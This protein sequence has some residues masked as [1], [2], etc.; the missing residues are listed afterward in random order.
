AG[1]PSGLGDTAA[2][3]VRVLLVA[4]AVD[5]DGLPVDRHTVA[6]VGTDLLDVAAD[7]FP[8]LRIGQPV[9]RGLQP[10]LGGPA[11]QQRGQI[12][13]AGQVRVG[14]ERD[15]HAV[16]DRVVH[17]RQ[18]LTRAAGVDREV[19]RGVCQ[20]KRAAGPPGDLDHLGVRLQR[21]GAVAAVVRTVVAAT[22]CDDLAQRDQLVGV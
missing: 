11:G 21:T 14:V 10:A 9:E 12:G 8:G 22:G 5:L 6:A 2:E 1:D 3:Q 17:Q 13:G 4:H 16:G 7:T 15:V 18:Q 19:H 20:V